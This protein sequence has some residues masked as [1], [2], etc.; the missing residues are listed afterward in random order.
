MASENIT[1]NKI[2]D[3]SEESLVEFKEKISQCNNFLIQTASLMINSMRKVKRQII[4]PIVCGDNNYI[5]LINLNKSSKE[6]KLKYT[7]RNS[8][9]LI[10]AE[11]SETYTRSENLKS[12]LE[13]IINNL[14]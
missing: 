2:E 4:K 9:D 7:I 13:F 8:A 11:L 6:L 12:D 5:V 10:V 14:G 3:L 1:V